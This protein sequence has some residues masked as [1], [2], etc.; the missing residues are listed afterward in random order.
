LSDGSSDA[1]SAPRRPSTAKASH[2][3]A[4]RP[5]TPH[6]PAKAVGSGAMDSKD[7]GTQPARGSEAAKDGCA[8]DDDTRDVV[9]HDL[10]GMD[11][12]QLQRVLGQPV[13]VKDSAPGKTWRYRNPCCELSV[14]LYPNLQ[15]HS[16]QVLSYEV[17]SDDSSNAAKPRC[18]AALQH[19]AATGPAA[20]E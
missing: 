5:A 8:K 3:T 19:D 2:P 16:Y 20:G 15:T 11:E 12:S 6:S 9:R 18:L 14:A 1:S 13:A 10:V 4:T 17:T 7:A